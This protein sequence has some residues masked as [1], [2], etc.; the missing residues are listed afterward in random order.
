MLNVAE[1]ATD[2]DLYTR[3]I[4]PATPSAR[5]ITKYVQLKFSY[6]LYSS[7]KRLETI[8]M[9]LV[10]TSTA[11]QGS[12]SDPVHQGCDGSRLCACRFLCTSPLTS[13]LATILVNAQLEGQSS[14]GSKHPIDVG[15]HICA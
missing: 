13:L 2:C 12:S 4:R 14:E 6:N 10:A 7:Y 1:R 3:I 5:T 9:R 15:I 11:Y 8:D